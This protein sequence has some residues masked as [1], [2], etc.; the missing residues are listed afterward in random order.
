MLQA[1]SESAATPRIVQNRLQILMQFILRVDFAAFNNRGK[2]FGQAFGIR[3]SNFKGKV[4]Q[5]AKSTQ[6]PFH[7]TSFNG[8]R[9]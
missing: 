5:L 7:P 2:S 1:Y 6:L 3:F 8:T 9:Q 4:H